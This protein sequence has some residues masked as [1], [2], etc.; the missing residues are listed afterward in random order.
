MQ[1]PSKGRTTWLG[2][3]LGSCITYW[4]ELISAIWEALKKIGSDEAEVYCYTSGLQL[5]SLT[6][7][8]WLQLVQPLH[9]LDFH[10]YY[11]RLE[12]TRLKSATGWITHPVLLNR[13]RGKPSKRCRMQSE[14]DRSSSNYSVFLEHRLVVPQNVLIHRIFL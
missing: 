13:A 14:L 10:P 7:S 12:N 11:H 1:I 2:P 8:Q 4:D 5:T 3:S 9:V 6:R